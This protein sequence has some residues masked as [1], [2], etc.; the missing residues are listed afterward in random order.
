MPIFHTLRY[1][2]VHDAN[3]NHCFVIYDSVAL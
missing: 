1:E 2:K 3:F